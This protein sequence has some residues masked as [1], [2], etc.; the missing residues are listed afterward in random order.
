MATFPNSLPIEVIKTG[1]RSGVIYTN[2]AHNAGALGL[3]FED[4]T[5]GYVRL[6]YDEDDD[7]KRTVHVIW[8]SMDISYDYDSHEIYIYLCTY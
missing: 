8:D 3:C 4:V 5:K 6:E 2:I 1:S 7:T